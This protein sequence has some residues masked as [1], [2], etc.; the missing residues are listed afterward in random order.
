MSIAISIPPY[1]AAVSIPELKNHAKAD[2]DILDDDALIRVQISAASVVIETATGANS[3]RNRVLLA[4]TFE[5]KLNCFS[6]G[7]I[8]IPKVPLITVTSITY[9]DNNG[10]TQTLG[11]DIYVVDIA[12][13]RIHLAYGQ[14]WP[15]T[16]NQPNAV[17]VTFVAGMAA[18]FTAV[19]ATDVLTGH[20]RTFTDG[21]AMQVLNSGG[22]LPGG[23]VA[24]TTYYVVSASG[25]AF[26]LSLTA[27]GTAVD[28]TSVGEGTHFVTF[29]VADFGTARAAILLKATQYYRNR[30]DDSFRQ[31]G[32]L[33]T[34]QRTID[35]LVGSI[36]A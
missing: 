25:S 23:L 5:L 11:T 30:G 24:G 36:Q 20:G 29:D 19:V 33:D 1:G 13:A 35:A 31:A 10:V 22:A 8:V 6:Y 14:V 21:D 3:S 15:S 9:V 34:T 2:V 17:T 28:V 4:T 18:V 27:G 12:N 26:K 16:R 32:S 7:C